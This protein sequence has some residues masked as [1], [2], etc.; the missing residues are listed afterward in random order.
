MSRLAVLPQYFYPKRLLTLY[1][2]FMA[3][4]E[5]GWYTTRLIRNFIRDY[6]VDMSEA[7]ESDPAAYKTFNDFF[8]RALKPGKQPGK[9]CAKVMRNVIANAL[10]LIHEAFDLAEHEVDLVDQPI[11]ITGAAPGW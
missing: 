4:N 10:H 3:R 9:W 6:K 2:G 11:E 1:A 5:W 8:T 7:V